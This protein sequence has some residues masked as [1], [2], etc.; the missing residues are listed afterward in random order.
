MTSDLD[1]NDAPPFKNE[2]TSFQMLVGGTAELDVHLLIETESDRS[3]NHRK[4]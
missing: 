3:Q 4:L 1:S 2:V